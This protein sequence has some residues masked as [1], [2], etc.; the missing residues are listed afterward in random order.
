MID[1]VGARAVILSGIGFVGASLILMGWM[2]RLWEYD[3]LCATEVLG[4]VLAGPIPNQVLVTNWFSAKRGQAMGYTYLGLGLGGT[5]SPVAINVLIG[6]FGWR[7]AF[8]IVG[9]V[10]L[11]VL[12][13]VG[14]WITRSTPGDLGLLPDGKVYAPAHSKNQASGDKVGRAV[15]TANFWHILLGCTLVIGAI[16]AVIQHLILFLEDQ[17]YSSGTASLFS[18][19]MLVSSLAGRVLVGYLADQFRKKNVMALFYLALGLAIPLLF[20][21]RRTA[22]IWGFVIIFGFAM[23]ADYMLIPLVTAECFGLKALGKLLALIIMGYSVGQWVAP[24]RAGRIFDAYHSYSL[25]WCIM[26]IAGVLGAIVIYVVSPAR[27]S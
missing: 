24:W 25:A 16:G 10:I 21:A 27:E 7:H 20:F 5:A 1:R 23:G 15:R 26:A 11:S 6:R 3:L 2:S 18:S 14:L 4:Y 9:A 12:F 17:G 22:V 13:P 8:E 19:C